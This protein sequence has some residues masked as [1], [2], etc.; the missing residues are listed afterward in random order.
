M[1]EDP[2]LDRVA[3]VVRAIVTMLPKRPGGSADLSDLQLVL[4]H[5]G[6]AAFGEGEADGPNRA[7]RAAEAALADL[8]LHLQS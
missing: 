6:K 1:S 2:T 7:T 4:Q 8:R 5:G 3:A